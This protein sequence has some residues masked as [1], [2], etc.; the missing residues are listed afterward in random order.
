MVQVAS[1][2]GFI[3]NLWQDVDTD[4]QWTGLF[5]F[6]VL[7]GEFSVTSLEKSDL[8]Q[9]LVG[10]RTRHDE[11]RV[12]SGTTQVDQSTVSQHDDVSTGL[13]QVSVDLRLDV[14][15]FN[16][17][18]LQGSD[19]DFNVEVTDVTD[20]GVF[21]HGFEVFTSDD[22][23]TTGGGDEDLT[24]GGDFVHGGDLVTG[25]GSLQGVDRINF[26]D[27]DSGTHTSQG[28]GTTLT[29]ITETSDNSD[30][31]GDHDVG[32][33]LD[34]ID[35][36]FSTTVQVV[37]LGLGDGVVDVDGWDL[38]GVVLQHLVEVVDTG[39][40]FLGKTVT[41]FQH[42]WVLVV[43][44]LGQ[45]TTVIQDQVELTGVLEGEQLLFDTPF[46]LFF[47]FTLPGKD[48]DTGGGDGGGG[49]VLGGVDVTG[50]PGDFS[51]KSDQGFDQH[52]GLDS[53]VQTTCDLGTGQR[54]RRTVLLSDVH[55]TWHLVFR[56][57]N[58][59][60]TEGSKGN[61]GNFVVSG[62]FG[63]VK[64]TPPAANFSLAARLQFKYFSSGEHVKRKIFTC[65]KR[66]QLYEERKDVLGAQWV[67][68]A[69][70]LWL[71]L[72]SKTLAIELCNFCSNRTTGGPAGVE[73]HASMQLTP[74][75]HL[76]I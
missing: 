59:F 14:D 55:Q 66:S 31:T 34:T 28:H 46:V 74:L 53:H 62:H 47:G 33:S 16:S 45:V 24:N 22:V 76:A 49:V 5:E 43:D 41:A 72:R 56:E 65:E 29:D 20:N 51:T 73:K 58:V 30:L 4:W 10:E 50:G 8:G 68:L 19:V 70:V 54:L 36:G 23:S 61:V 64:G 63:C 42:F 18:G 25:D 40:G 27:N 75:N 69:L 12:T 21:W 60:S 44:H 15:A 37:E 9:D 7:L 6:R 35:Q 39:G 13:H 3:Q 57:L 11:G 26:G 52:S 71:D 2:N 32:G 17:L 38:Q 48:W 1:G 67:G